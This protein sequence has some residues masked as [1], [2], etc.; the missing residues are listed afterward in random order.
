MLRQDYNKHP[1]D[2]HPPIEQIPRVGCR[3]P[4]GDDQMVMTYC[5]VASAEEHCVEHH[6]TI[7]G[8]W[9]SMPP[10]VVQMDDADL[11]LWRTGEVEPPLIRQKQRQ[12]NCLSHKIEQILMCVLPQLYDTKRKPA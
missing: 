2:W 7:D 3:C 12:R 4:D 5:Q 9:E 10:R 1:D 11:G 8:G 6:Y